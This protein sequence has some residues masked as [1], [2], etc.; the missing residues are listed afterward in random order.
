MKKLIFFLFCF[1]SLSFCYGQEKKEEHSQLS[2]AYCCIKKDYCGEKGKKCP[3]CDQVLIR[4]GLFYC[5]KCTM[6]R[7]KPGT[8]GRCDM[9]LVKMERKR[10]LLPADNTSM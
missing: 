7:K 8:C 2:Q 10:E 9:V 6:S 3:K 5:P 1:A 4:E